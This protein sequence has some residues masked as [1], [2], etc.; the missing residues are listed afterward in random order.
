MS[1]IQR[2]QS[3]IW[4]DDKL[5][6]TGGVVSG[7]TTAHGRN[8]NLTRDATV[9]DIEDSVGDVVARVVSSVKKTLNVT[10]LP[11][12]TSATMTVT[13]GE[14]AVNSWT[15]KPGWTISVADGTQASTTSVT[16]GDGTFVVGNPYTGTY[17]VMSASQNRTNNAAATVDLVLETF[18]DNDTTA[19]VSQIRA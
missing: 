10:V 14:V 17:L 13:D 19:L 4:G 7:S 15:I 2:G 3:V 11:Y 6:Y 1:V 5:T 9:T 16:D 8:A 18:D 12:V